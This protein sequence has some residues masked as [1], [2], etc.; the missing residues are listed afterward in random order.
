MRER[1][2]PTFNDFLLRVGYGGE[3]IIRDDL[4]LLLEQL[5]VKHCRDGM[6]E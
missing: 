2:D 1:I 6:P 5:T 4:I 3:Q